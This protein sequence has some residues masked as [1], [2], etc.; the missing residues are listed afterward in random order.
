[1]NENMVNEKSYENAGQ[2][3][4]KNPSEVRYEREDARNP[5]MRNSTPYF[6][7]M[8]LIYSL[9]FAFAFYRNFIGITYPLITAVTLGI[10]ILFLRKNEISWRKP[11]WWYLAGS[12]LLGISTIF[13]TKGFVIFFNT[14]GILLLITVFMVRQVYCDREWNFGQYLCNLLFFYLCMIPEVASPFI[15]LGNYLKKCKK[16]EKQKNK[17]LKYILFGILIGLPMVLIVI[18]LLSSAD[19]IFSKLIGTAFHKFRSQIV[20]SP[21]LFL[22][23]FLL[24]LGFF[25]IYSFLSA[26]TLNNMP[27]WK[28]KKEK[29]NPVTAITFLSMVTVVYL[30]FCVIQMIFLFTGGK[31]LPEGYTYAAYARQGFFQL[32]FV[33]IFNFV[34]VLLCLSIF[35]VSK[36]LKVFLLIF[37]GCTYVMIFS[38]AYRMLL[39]IDAYHLSFLRVLV[40]W[41]LGM[42]VF[43]M[44]G[45][46]A[47][48]IKKKFYLF[49]Y[50]MVVITVCYLVFSFGRVD[51]LVASYNISHLKE[52]I[53]YE[54]V[55][56]LTN[57]SMDVA[58]A[59][60][61]YHFEHTCMKKDFE[62]DNYYFRRNQYYE[63]SYRDYYQVEGRELQLYFRECRRCRLDWEFQKV[64][65]ATEDMGV[66]TFHISKYQ[67]RK[68][69]EAYF[70]H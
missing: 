19:Q 49:R 63:N 24:L 48:I 11:N 3:S 65:D 44:V 18:E 50:C 45:V 4:G 14:M 10:C 26:L 40:L 32:L 2:Q 12:I 9:C 28:Q 21:N 35:Q 25:G 53:S 17:N 34:L 27:E 69:A 59:L 68:A 51:A 43:L 38:S 42:L 37:S 23:I 57:L 36:V 66:R 62:S 7:G 29:K 52:D 13:T 1:M 64:L 58:P 54:D 6:L 22:V 8:A 61:Q 30:I 31:L 39:Y 33:C 47:A 60:S 70:N 41:F 5:I 56:Y 46:I 20:F 15:H 16:E 67:A 55:E